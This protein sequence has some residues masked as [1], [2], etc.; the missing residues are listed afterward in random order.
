MLL[1]ADQTHPLNLWSD[2][3]NL[4]TEGELNLAY[5]CEKLM[6][7]LR[8]DLSL[9]ADSICPLSDPSLMKLS[10]AESCFLA[11]PRSDGRKTE[12]AQISLSVR[13]LVLTEL[14]EMAW[15]KKTVPLRPLRNLLQTSAGGGFRQMEAD[16][17]RY[18]SLL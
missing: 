8:S 13:V 17:D 11:G 3:G 4:K 6:T 5:N 16:A 2:L 9:M 7:V 18:W 10:A 15:Q 14:A 1:K 12:K